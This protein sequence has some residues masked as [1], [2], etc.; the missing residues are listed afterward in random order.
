MTRIK[1]GSEIYIEV[2]IRDFR[3][4]PSSLLDP[5][6][7]AF[8]NLRNPSGS[9][10]LT[11]APMTKRSTGVYLYRI[12]TGPTDPVGVWEMDFK[13]SHGTATHLTL[14]MGSFEL[15]TA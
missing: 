3:T 15:V 5:D 14:A 6:G 12:Q 4:T 11:L 9:A 2:E 7:G 13:A 10:V 1:R 8:F